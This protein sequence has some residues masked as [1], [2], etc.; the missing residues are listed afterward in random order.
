MKQAATVKKPAD[1]QPRRVAQHSEP[2]G[3]LALAGGKLAT[4]PEA[5]VS[6]PLS[7]ERALALQ[8]TAGNAA[9]VRAVKSQQAPPIQRNSPV[10]ATATKAKGAAP[11]R[12]LHGAAL[13]NSYV[14]FVNTLQDIANTGGNARGKGLDTVVFETGMT[15]AQRALLTDFRSAI[16][17]LWSQK[18]G[19]A[20]GALSSYLLLSPE[21]FAECD[22]AARQKVLNENEVGIYKKNLNILYTDYLRPMAYS[23]EKKQA[24]E[25]SDLKAP[26]TAFQQQR[27]ED[28]ERE[29]NA[30][31]QMS[32][33][34]SKLTREAVTHIALKDAGMGK[35]IF[36][37]VHLQ[38]TIEEKLE[39]AKKRG[40][41]AKT[42]TAFDLVNKVAGSANFLASTSL[43]V[44]KR[45]AEGMAARYAS[46]AAHELAENWEKIA[47]KWGTKLDALKT[48]GRV[49][50]ALAVIA[51]VIKSVRAI[52]NGDWETAVSEAGNA[53]VDVMAMVASGDA[54]PLLGAITITIKAE[55]AAI[56]MAAE[57]AHWCRDEQV[58]DAAEE[59]INA[60]SVVGKNVALDFV[61]DLELYWRQS[62]VSDIALKQAERAAPRMGQGLKHLMW[63]Y[64]RLARKPD[65]A[66]A[67]G[68]KAEAWLKGRIDMPFE[69]VDGPML[70]TMAEG[71]QDI[72]AGANAMGK[73]VRTAYPTED[74]KATKAE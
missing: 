8:R 41:L 36:E 11:E 2:Q 39:W 52:I 46:K 28:A 24:L 71:I 3:T 21:L 67:L 62:N 35:D 4:S 15:S 16:T 58:R 27:L 47:K 1:R 7:S 68:P 31:E 17:L 56:S 53:A 10:G 29:F 49:I 30:A 12:P 23:E 64:G 51:D 63:A 18:P 37:L 13:Y 70:L 40:V 74:R 50:G 34:V 60:C 33:E 73:Y 59:F 45:F 42:A 69:T 55:I 25:Q 6:R 9:T 19:S 72:F 48:V 26:D 44:G 61:A 38:G 57:F 20:Q 5:L 43:E 32:E 54:A 65:L 14:A 66:Y 22:R